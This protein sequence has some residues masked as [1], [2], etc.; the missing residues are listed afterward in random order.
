MT[1]TPESFDVYALGSSV[2]TLSVRVR[3]EDVEALGLSGVGMAQVSSERLARV[4]TSLGRKP[5]LR[6]AGGSAENTVAG[7]A[8]MGG[9]AAYAGGLGLDEDGRLCRESLDRLGVRQTA[10]PKP[11]PTGLCLILVTPDGERTML[12][13]LGVSG[14]LVPDDVSVELVAASRWL[15]VEGF[16][17][18]S[19]VA[20]ETVAGAL[21]AAAAA[22]TPV[23]LSLS[24][25]S[26][27]ERH[28]PELAR[29]V[30]GHV[31]LV[32]ANEAEAEAFT[33]QGE[34]RAAIEA[35]AARSPAA[36]VTRGD[37]GC[38]VASDGEVRSVGARRVRPVDLTGAGDLCAA[39]VLY[40]LA[41]G[42]S[43]PEGADLG[44]RLAARVIQRLGPRLE[45]RPEDSARREPAAH[46][47]ITIP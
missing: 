2:V 19:A 41:R 44:C 13:H 47:A 37:R 34:P 11:G 26:I 15:Y 12:T 43:L 33:G 27:V 4:R 20:R 3:H 45:D 42:R 22:G 29:V 21:D 28:R 8:Q 30:E 40:A 36:L 39:G 23:A 25:R 16:L 18:A 35:L 1:G 14:R 46:G 17:F 24:A 10:A 32:L 5:M 38:L 6:S 9:A 7:I 31:D